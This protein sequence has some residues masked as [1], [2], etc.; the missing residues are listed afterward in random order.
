MVK[1]NS[2]EDYLESILM[3]HKRNGFARSVDVARQLGVT[4]PSV[5]NAMKKLRGR[6]LVYLNDKG[7]IFFT[8]AGKVIAER[9]YRK[10]VLLKRIL[11]G[12]GVNEE[13]ASKDA[14]G[15]EHVIS[16]ETY[17][18]LN[19]FFKAHMNIPVTE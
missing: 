9:I 18:C 2:S 11:T 1:N 12:I 6:N 19:D 10:H 5:C 7:Y 4:K 13:T 15:I 14:C 8:D 17:E 16:D 3:L